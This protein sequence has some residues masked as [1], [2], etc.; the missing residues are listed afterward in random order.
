MGLYRV[1][2]GRC[3]EGGTGASEVGYRSLSVSVARRRTV[4]VF[5]ADLCM[6]R[7]TKERAIA[8]LASEVE[9][10]VVVKSKQRARA[11]SCCIKVSLERDVGLEGIEK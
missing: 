4:R 1:C 2:V 8:F 10:V 6:I 3:S 9:L 7:I 11:M 5:L